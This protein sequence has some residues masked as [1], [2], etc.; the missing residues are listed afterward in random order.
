MLTVLSRCASLLALLALAFALP[1][2]DPAP[3]PQAVF[4][5]SVERVPVATIVQTKQGHPVVD[6]RREDFQLLDNGRPKEITEFQSEP[7]PVSLLLLVDLSG[8]MGIDD[9]WNRAIDISGQLELFLKPR[10]DEVG[11]YAFDKKLK[12]LE[13]FGSPLGDVQHTLKTLRPFGLTSLYDAIAEAGKEMSHR[14]GT[15]RAVVAL[16]DGEDN[17]SRMNLKEVTTLASAIDVPVYIVMVASEVERAPQPAGPPAH[18][19]VDQGRLEDLA[20]LT[21]GQLF[22]SGSPTEDRRAAGHIVA[23]LRQQYLIVFEPDTEPGWHA[24]TVVTRQKDLVVRTRNGYL[25]SSRPGHD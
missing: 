14:P 22:R 19:A 13:P 24:I 11:L 9:R 15:R 8:S 20:R 3:V 10:E 25:V 1:G 16:T 12:V 4:R 2:Q 7:T 18:S 17:A 6:L 5:K 21:G 23:E